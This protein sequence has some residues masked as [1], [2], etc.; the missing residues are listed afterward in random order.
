MGTTKNPKDFRELVILI[1]SSTMTIRQLKIRYSRS[2]I[3][4]KGG[5]WLFTH[6]ILALQDKFSTSV[7]LQYCYSLTTEPIYFQLTCHPFE[8]SAKRLVIFC[9]LFFEMQKFVIL[10]ISTSESFNVVAG[11]TSCSGEDSDFCFLLSD[12]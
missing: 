1:H 10:S 6:D 3:M 11:H 9:S 7:I 4:K 8:T 12:L 5:N 2:N